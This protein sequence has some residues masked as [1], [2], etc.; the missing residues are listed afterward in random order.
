[1][2]LE[3]SAGVQNCPLLLPDSVAKWRIRYLVGI[4]QQVV[5][6]GPVAPEVQGRGVE[7]GRQV[8]KAVQHLLALPQLAV[9]VKVGH[10]DDALQ[11]I[12]LGQ[13]PDDLVDLV[14]DLLIA[15][16]FHHIRK[17]AARGHVQQHVLLARVLVGDIFNKQLHQDIILVLGGVHAAPQLIAAFP[18]GAVQF[19]FFQ[20]HCKL[21]CVI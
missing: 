21:S 9:V 2:I 8:G 16:K 15:L 13:P 12:S 6:P 5:A 20:G 17:P 1:M 4:P 14:A 19:R 18:Q 7:D 3:T 10:I 11:I